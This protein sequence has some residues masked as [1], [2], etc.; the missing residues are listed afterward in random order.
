M[1]ISVPT[2]SGPKLVTKQAWPVFWNNC[3]PIPTMFHRSTILH[4]LDS[5]FS[6]G[7]LTTIQYNENNFCYMMLID[8][9]PVALES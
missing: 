4:L 3:R 6:Q 2:T 9:K 7:R 5:F 8:L 1:R